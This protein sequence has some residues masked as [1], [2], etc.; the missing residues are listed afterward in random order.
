MEFAPISPVVSLPNV[1]RAIKD[2]SRP[3]KPIAAVIAI[4]RSPFIFSSSESEAVS[5]T[6]LRAH[7]T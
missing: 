4:A 5:Y 1:A 6:H 7:E 2:T 3:P